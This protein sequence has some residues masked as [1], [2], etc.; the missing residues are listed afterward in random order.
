MLLR[1]AWSWLAFESACTHVMIGEPKSANTSPRNRPETLVTVPGPPAI[2][3]DAE[4][5]LA[6]QLLNS[7]VYRCELHSFFKHRLQRVFVQAELGY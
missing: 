7:G 2:R 1:Q 3:R 5:V 6:P 4:G